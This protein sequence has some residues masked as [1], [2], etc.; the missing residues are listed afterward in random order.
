[1]A[2][3]TETTLY[4]KPPSG[5][6]GYGIYTADVSNADT[7]TFDNFDEI[8]F[9][10]VVKLADNTELTTTMATNVVTI[11]DATADSDNVLIIIIGVSS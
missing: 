11:A 9:R 8:L 10:T 3:V 7:V 6:I 1:M 4:E 5:G 2:D